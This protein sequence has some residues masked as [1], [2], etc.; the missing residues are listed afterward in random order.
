MKFR[1]LWEDLFDIVYLELFWVNKL[2][3]FLLAID[4]EIEDEVPL[5]HFCLDN[6]IVIGELTHNLGCF[7][8]FSKLRV[9]EVIRSKCQVR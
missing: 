9:L 6:T 8:M 3:V 7:C 5:V 1:S 4:C 2:E